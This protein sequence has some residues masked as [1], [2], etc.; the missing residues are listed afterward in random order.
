MYTRK[1]RAMCCKRRSKKN[2][3]E[4]TEGLRKKGGVNNAPTTKPP[5][6]PKPQGVHK[7]K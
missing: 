2:G 5:P 7:P 1:W 6:S 3:L 4:I